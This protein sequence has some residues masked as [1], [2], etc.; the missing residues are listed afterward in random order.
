MARKTG[1]VGNNGIADI[2]SRL[3]AQN[4]ANGIRSRPSGARHVKPD[5]TNHPKNSIG[6]HVV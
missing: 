2:N 1:T 4:L 6:D 3:L 5:M